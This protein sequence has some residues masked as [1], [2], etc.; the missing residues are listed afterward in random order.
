MLR[1]EGSRW[2]IGPQAD[3]PLLILAPLLALALGLALGLTPLATRRVELFGARAS[4]ADGFIA[5]FIIAHL[6][7]VFFRSHANPEVFEKYPFRFTYLPLA[8][9]ATLLAFP[10]ARVAAA[11]L[12]V[13][14]DAYHSSLQTFGLGRIY[15]RLAGN[16]PRSGRLP[17]ILLNHLLYIGPILGGASLMLHTRVFQGFDALGRPELSALGPALNAA[18]PVMARV[19]LSIGGTYAAG[20][21]AWALWRRNMPV[22]KACLYGATAL[23]S[24]WA[25]GF[26]PL[27]MALFIM[28]FFHALQYF[29]LV[30]R[31]EEG[32]IARVFACEGNRR[33]AFAAYLGAGLTYGV[34]GGILGELYETALCVTLVVSL[35]HFWY[36]GFV[37]SVRAGEA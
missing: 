17:E 15:D 22:Q 27:G 19:L 26:N 29:A 7:L 4:I 10:W 3:W 11:V 16:D 18:R 35:M 32:N 2:I 20:F 33:R 9:F 6:A 14:W 24:V 37:W 8:L 1:P 5:V 21:I 25:W 23:T 31:Y 30:W 34:L 28:N 12:A 36:D 13:W